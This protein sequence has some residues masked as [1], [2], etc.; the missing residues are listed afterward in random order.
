M[1]IQYR[2]HRCASLLKAPHYSAGK[3]GKCPACA[4]IHIVPDAN[5]PLRKSIP[6]EIH[7]F[8]L[9][10]DYVVPV[11]AANASMNSGLDAFSARTI[12][13]RVKTP[14]NTLNSIQILGNLIL[15]LSLIH[16]IALAAGILFLVNAIAQAMPVHVFGNVIG[17]E[18]T[19]V[20]LI[21]VFSADCLIIRA[22]YC[23]RVAQDHSMAVIGAFLACIPFF[24][25]FS[26]PFGVTVLVLL[27]DPE[28]EQKFF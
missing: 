12:P 1:A 13:H 28:I 27:L 25:P 2:C 18:L 23:M 20:I 9:G 17:K 5:R 15:G 4:V 6:A 7:D 26:V 19:L 24:N 3:S 16:A 22:G 14:R 11:L 8:L 21:M 10:A